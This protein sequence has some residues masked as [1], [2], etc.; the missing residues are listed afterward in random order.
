M[1][2]TKKLKNNDLQDIADVRDIKALL[3]EMTQ[4]R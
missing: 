2:Q 1:I 3:A 4:A